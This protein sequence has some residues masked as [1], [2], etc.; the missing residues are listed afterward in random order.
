MFDRMAIGA[1]IWRL[2]VLGSFW[3]AAYMGLLTLTT[4]IVQYCCSRRDDVKEVDDHLAG[5]QSL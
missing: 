1:P 4:A 5:L 3:L 2:F